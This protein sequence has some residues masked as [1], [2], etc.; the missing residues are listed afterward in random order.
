MT[1]LTNCASCNTPLKGQFCHRCGEKKLDQ[2]SRSLGHLLSALTQELT[3][4][5]GKILFTL[6]QFFSAPGQQ[7][8]DFHLGTRQRYFSLIS[9]FFIFNVLY[10]FFTPLTDFSLSLREQFGQLHSGLIVPII[11]SYLNEHN[12]TIKEMNAKYALVSSSTAKSTIILSVPFFA[13]FVWLINPY[14]RYYLQDHVMY[15][16]NAYAFILI[17][18]TLLVLVSKSVNFI[19]GEAIASVKTLGPVFLIW[20]FYFLWSSQKRVYQE[21]AWRSLAKM[22]LLL[23]ALFASHFIFR[24]IQFWLTWWQV[25]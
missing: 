14:K 15:A 9:L 18:P 4:L 6:K 5:D 23:I 8:L 22:P 12:I 16:L 1:E 21:S 20:L 24:F 13:L 3:S 10:F 19:A 11:E 17:V 7:C 25:T 2:E